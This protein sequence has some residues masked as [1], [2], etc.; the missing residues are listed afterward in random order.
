MKYSEI[1]DT[2]AWTPNS[3]LSNL[4]CAICVAQSFSCLRTITHVG[5]SNSHSVG[6]HNKCSCKC[7]RVQ[8]HCPLFVSANLHCRLDSCDSIGPFAAIWPPP[9]SL[10]QICDFQHVLIGIIKL[11]V[12]TTGSFATWSLF[13]NREFRN[14]MLCHWLCWTMAVQSLIRCFV[15]RI[16]ERL[17]R[18]HQK[19]W[20]KRN[21]TRSL[22]KPKQTETNL[23]PL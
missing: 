2:C 19:C 16:E 7:G 14:F 23:Q 22:Y 1:Y 18:N 10:L 13:Y 15:C 3:V 17:V 12:N 11:H 8:S 6:I 20:P 5:L 4:C 21:N 9:I